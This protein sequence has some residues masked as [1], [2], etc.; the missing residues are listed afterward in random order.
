MLLTNWPTAFAHVDCDAFYASCERA[1]R[2]DLKHTPVCVLSNQNAF[3][4]AKTYDAKRLGVTTAMSVRDARKIVPHAAFLPPDFAYYGQMS[5]RVFAILRRFSPDVEL[6]SIDEGFIDMRG[7]RSL[8][9]KS[10]RD[11]A[12]EIKESVKHEV[13][14]TVSI[15]VSVTKTLAKIASELN[16][17]DGVTI[18]PGRA[19]EKFLP[20]VTVKDVPGIA[21]SRCAL[22]NLF[23]IETAADYANAPRAL[24]RRLM[25]KVGTDLWHELRGEAIYPLELVPKL[26][27]SI[28]RT[29]SMGEI[30]SDRDRIAAHMTRHV[31]RLAT[32]LVTKR[33]VARRIVFYL[34]VRTF[35]SFGA[36]CRFPYPTASYFVLSG[37]AERALDQLY[38]PGSRYRACG[39]IASEISLAERST[40]D[41]FGVVAR[42]ERE[43]RLMATVDDINRKYGKGTAAML[44]TKLIRR[45]RRA[46]RFR[47]PMMAVR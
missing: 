35:E 8:W 20:G 36:E 12:E 21:G 24:I 23:K 4:V 13:G 16:K 40:Q 32:E 11:L 44:A 9:R 29:A 1:R 43:A 17:P 6:Y 38:T 30:T 14:I 27:K 15:G 5:D 18:V 26:P 47:Y 45:Q 22:L 42:E 37:A 46:V 33:Y 3:V 39:V 28:M 25:G 10:Y 41:L 34:E 19:I 7:L 2:P 31:T